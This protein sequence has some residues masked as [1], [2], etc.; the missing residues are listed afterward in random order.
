MNKIFNNL[1]IIILLL[2]CGCSQTFYSQG[3][4][5]FEKDQYDLAID[6]F[7]KEIAKNPKN[8]SAWRELGVTYFKKG[9]LVKAEDALEQANLIKP[10]A[11]T[12]LFFGAAVTLNQKSN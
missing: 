11:R 1:L 5:F 6:S 4:S 10:D 9:N 2:F 3:R 7:Y 8:A 12:H